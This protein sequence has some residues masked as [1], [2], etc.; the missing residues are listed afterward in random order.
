ML[1]NMIYIYIYH[2]F[3]KYLRIPEPGAKPGLSN[4]EPEKQPETRKNLPAIY[5][6][7]IESMI[8]TTKFTIF[9]FRKSLKILSNEKFELGFFLYVVN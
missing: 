3:S 4:S 5:R 6:L 7:H 8:L 2:I 9:L 1:E